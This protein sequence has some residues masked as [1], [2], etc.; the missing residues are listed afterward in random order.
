MPET[1]IDKVQIS[2]NEKFANP[3]HAVPIDEH[4]FYSQPARINQFGVALL[5]F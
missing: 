3:V 1:T 5:G 4:F 2:A